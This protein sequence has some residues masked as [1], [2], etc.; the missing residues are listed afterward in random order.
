MN[1]KTFIN[2]I[3]QKPAEFKNENFVI[4]QMVASFVEAEADN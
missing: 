3:S 4:R 1:A 2:G